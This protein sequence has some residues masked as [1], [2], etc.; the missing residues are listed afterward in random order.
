MR[1]SKTIGAGLMIFALIAETAPTATC[2]DLKGIAQREFEA[3]IYNTCRELSGKNINP[4]KRKLVKEKF[5][6]TWDS[7]ATLNCMSSCGATT[8]CVNE[9]IDNFT[10]SAL[11][12]VIPLLTTGWCVSG[13]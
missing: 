11:N 5:L 6:E 1:L 3:G 2:Q 10:K 8:S 9:Y 12:E 13:G 7:Q 4:A